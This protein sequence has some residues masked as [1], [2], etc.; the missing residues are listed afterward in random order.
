MKADIHG[1]SEEKERPMKTRPVRHQTESS[2][3]FEKSVH[4]D[5]AIFSRI[6]TEVLAQHGGELL[7]HSS[8]FNRN[9]F[10]SEETLTAFYPGMIVVG[11][12]VNSQMNLGYPKKEQFKKKHI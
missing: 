8:I 2:S 7:L 4:H 9:K 10:M 5:P 11:T 3:D 12:Q 6:K 1:S